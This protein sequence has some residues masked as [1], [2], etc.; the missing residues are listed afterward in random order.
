VKAC[1]ADQKVAKVLEHLRF[2]GAL[3]L[4]EVM[5]KDPETGMKL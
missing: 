2:K 3:D 4:F 1:L 5:K